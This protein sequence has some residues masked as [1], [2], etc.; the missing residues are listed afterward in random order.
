MEGPDKL[1]TFIMIHFEADLRAVV[2]DRPAILYWCVDPDALGTFVA[3][4]IDH[5]WVFMHPWDE[6]AEPREAFTAARCA[7]LVQRA[8]GRD[9]VA[10]TIRDVSPWKMSAQVAA[11]FRS[12]RVFLI[13]DSAHRFPP[14]GGLGLNSGVQDAHNLAWKL[15]WVE[16]G[17][18]APSLLDTYETE[19]RPIA[20]HNADQSLLNAMKMLQAF[21][22]LGLSDDREASRRAFAETLET[23]AGRARMRAALDEQQ[24]HFDM[25]GLQLGFAYEQGAVVP[26]GSVPPAL[27]NPVRE[28]VPSGRPGARVAHG[29]VET[30]RGRCS[31]L[32]LLATDRFTLVVGAQAPAFYEATAAAMS[33]DLSLLRVE[34]AFSDPDGDWARKTGIGKTGALLIR[35]DQH[36]AWRTTDPTIAA[37]DAIR[38]VLRALVG[39]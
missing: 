32:D 1:Q 31:V 37:G 18:A 29:W 3:H 25:L 12:G 38:V 20:Q 19:R 33:A 24:D 9:D 8:L 22:A 28:F 11:S 2:R 36:V 17:R 26:D 13:G 14:S 15:A 27:E 30:G 6:V 39:R 5:T 23:V 7:A 35:P 21:G 34:E 4:H 10:M 16:A